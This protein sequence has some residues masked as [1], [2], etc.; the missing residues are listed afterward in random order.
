MA[1]IFDTVDIFDEVA[2]EAPAPANLEGTNIPSKTSYV[3]SKKA[4]TSSPDWKASSMAERRVMLDKLD[5][6]YGGMKAAPAT[7]KEKVKAVTREAMPYVRPTLEGVGAGLGGVIGTT[8]GAVLGLATGPAAPVATPLAAATGG[9]GGAGLGYSMGAKLADVLDSASDNPTNRAASNDVVGQ[10]AQAQ[11]D[12]TTGANMEMGGQIAGKGLG[13]AAKG[14]QKT[15]PVANE[16]LGM[17]AKQALTKPAASWEAA[18]EAV[19]GRYN[20]QIEEAVRSGIRAIRPSVTGKKA[21]Y[22]QFEQSGEKASDGVKS[23][24]RMKDEGKLRLTDTDTGEVFTGLPQNIRQTAEAID[25]T[26]KEIFPKIEAALKQGERSGMAAGVDADIDLRPFA[27]ALRKQ[28]LNPVTRT[29]RPNVAKAL[30]DEAA[31]LEAQGKF[32]L[33]QAEEALQELNSTLEPLY[34]NGTYHKSIDFKTAQFYRQAIDDKL[35]SLDIPIIA[36]MKREYG[37]LKSMEKDVLH[38]AVVLERANPRSLLDFSDVW[39][40][41]EILG[42]AV[43]ANPAM[44][45]K[46][47]VGKVSKGV[48]KRANDPN[49]AVSKMFEKVDKLYK[50]KPYTDTVEA[51]EPTA[52]VTRPTVYDESTGTQIPA[53]GQGGGAVNAEGNYHV[54][55]APNTTMVSRTRT[56]GNLADAY[57]PTVG[58]RRPSAW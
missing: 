58:A 49:R 8:G 12:F 27:T 21:S 33:T 15:F 39:T 31:R 17:E 3:A 35:A 46:G 30:E 57:D 41:G 19:K 48:L 5:E 32:T 2:P 52:T 7:F 22:G 53:Y 14:L 6:S 16:F 51:P 55:P 28:A 54:A 4:L 43:T 29:H 26:K 25:Q 50:R 10:L 40:N 37:A 34:N 56:G 42:G 13:L 24:I 38:R 45:T 20:E 1:D 44:V 23:I 18:G 11:R 36:P 9:V 47:I